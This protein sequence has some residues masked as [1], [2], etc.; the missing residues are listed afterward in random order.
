MEGAI[1]PEILVACPNVGFLH[2]GQ[3]RSSFFFLFLITLLYLYLYLNH[4]FSI[5][6]ISLSILLIIIAAVIIMFYIKANIDSKKAFSKS[7]SIIKFEMFIVLIIA[8]IGN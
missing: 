3:S 6:T 8:L 1:Q 4:Y 7:S 5:L 2:L